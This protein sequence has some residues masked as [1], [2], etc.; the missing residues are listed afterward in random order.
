MSYEATITLTI[1]SIE[2]DMPKR[3]R[4]EEALRANLEW[5]S[6]VE[7]L[8]TTLFEVGAE[9]DPEQALFVVV[10]DAE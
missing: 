2:G 9:I 4:V 1:K 7:A 5:G 8:N 10:K 6:T 3:A